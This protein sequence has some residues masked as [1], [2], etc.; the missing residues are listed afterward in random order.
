[1][2]EIIQIDYNTAKD[3]LLPRHYSGRIPSISYAY[4][5]Y[6]NKDLVGV[7]TVGKPA[8]NSLCKGVCWCE[9]SKAFVAQV[10]KNKGKQE[11]LGLFKTESEAFNTYKKAKESFVKEQANKWKDKIDD[12]AYEA[13]MNYEVMIDD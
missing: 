2:I 4:G 11:R 3:F 9:K 12:R 7:L 8:S 6:N 13:L 5:C 1:M 10:N